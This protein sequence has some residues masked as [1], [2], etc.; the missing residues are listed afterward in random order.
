MFLALALTFLRHVLTD[1]EP[2]VY[3]F[4]VSPSR[5]WW[6]TLTRSRRCLTGASPKAWWLPVSRGHRAHSSMRLSRRGGCLLSSALYAVLP[7]E[8]LAAAGIVHTFRHALASRDVVLYIDNQSDAPPNERRIEVKD[9]QL[10][11]TA[12]KLS[13]R[14]LS[15]YSEPPYAPNTVERLRLPSWALRDAQIPLA[16]T[17]RQ[18]VCAAAA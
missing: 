6:S 5:Q 18:L 2:R 16:T 9:S 17:F 7:L 8:L 3:R 13:R 15:R 4:A 11:T 12:D 10:F 1:F 14:K